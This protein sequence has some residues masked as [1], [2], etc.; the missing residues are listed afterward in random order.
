M[1]PWA[2]FLMCV[3]LVSFPRVAWCCPSFNVTALEAVV[4]GMCFA[5]ANEI[6]SAPDNGAAIRESIALH[7]TTT[8]VGERH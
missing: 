6:A 3:L 7:Q 2:L 4:N 5:I 8:S 1:T